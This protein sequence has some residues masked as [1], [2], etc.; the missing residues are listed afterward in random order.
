MKIA[1]NKILKLVPVI[2]LGALAFACEDD[3]DKLDPMRMF[4][5]AGD[6]SSESGV[7]QV[8]LTWNPSLYT[9]NS[10]GVTYTVEVAADTLFETPVIISAQTDTSGVVLTDD[11]L[12]VRKNYFARIKANAL[13]DR[14]ESKWVVSNRFKITGEQVMLPL[15]NPEIKATSAILRWRPTSGLTRV[16]LVPAGGEPIEVPVTEEALSSGK[17]MVNNLQPNTSYSLDIFSGKK[18]KGFASFTTTNAI[19]YTTILSS[20]ADLAGAI[21]ASATGAVIG[22]EP[23]VYDLSST[24]ELSG[25]TITLA[26]VSG[27]PAD[28]K[29]TFKQFDLTGTGAGIKVSGIDFD[30]APNGADYFLNLVGDAANF[31]NFIVENSIIRNV[32]NTILRGNRANKNDYKVNTI[33]FDYS[34]IYN[35]GESG[36]YSFLVLDEMEFKSLEITNSTLYNIGRQLISWATDLSTYPVPNIV[37]TRSTLLNF[38][39]RD[40]VLLDA[41]ANMVKFTMQNSIIGNIP[42]PGSAISTDAIRTASSGS[43]L[44]VSYNNFFNLTNGAGAA[45]VFPNGTQLAG[46]T[47]INPGWGSS[48]TSFTLPADSPL[49]MSS[50][51][52]GPVGAPRW[53]Y[54]NF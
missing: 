40:Y 30:G 8:K 43:T 23:G 4:T 41:R 20:G 2:L 38:G 45:L 32:K 42:S 12:E 19:A 54:T 15:Y 13:G 36:G 33:R 28:T 29:V 46:N 50:N 18:S 52:S 1:I 24:I 11:D 10:S 31:T 39:S 26:S 25:K 35:I 34:T 27:N 14:P 47:D 7:S 49:R 48:T 5:P 22:L 9:T 16:V 44:T 53:I 6:I 21:A 37:I 17:M 3:P 51:T